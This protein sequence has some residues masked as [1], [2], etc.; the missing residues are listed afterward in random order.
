QDVLPVGNASS[1]DYSKWNYTLN[2][3]YAS[4]QLGQN[5]ITAKLSCSNNPNIISHSSVNVTGIT[6]IGLNSTSTNYTTTGATTKPVSSNA[7]ARSTTTT[8]ATTKPVSSNATARST[9][10]T[11]ATTK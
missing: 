5:K 4:I 10:T 3:S 8:G 7:T 1:K 11:G 2:P 9:T 6:K